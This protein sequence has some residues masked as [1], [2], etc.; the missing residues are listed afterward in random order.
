MIRE[1]IRDG[2]D[3]MQ[4]VMSTVIMRI[5]VIDQLCLLPHQVEVDAV[6]PAGAR[7]RVLIAASFLGRSQFFLTSTRHEIFRFQDDIRVAHENDARMVVGKVCFQISQQ[8]FGIFPEISSFEVGCGFVHT[9]PAVVRILHG[10]DE[11]VPR[12]LSD[13][14][15]VVSHAE[16]DEVAVLGNLGYLLG[17]DGVSRRSG[18]RQVVVARSYALVA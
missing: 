10:P 16:H 13:A 12:N 8:A 2:G 6:R 11:A 3:V 9:A 14:S 1:I 15:F 4:G 5:P 7:I 18:G 17:P